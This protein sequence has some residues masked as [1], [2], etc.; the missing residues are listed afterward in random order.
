VSIQP[1]GAGPQEATL[2]GEV[3]ER[4]LDLTYQCTNPNCSNMESDLAQDK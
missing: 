4:G 1:P 3:V 2:H